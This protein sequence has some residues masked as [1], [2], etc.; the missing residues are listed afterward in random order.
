MDLTKTDIKRTIQGHLSSAGVGRGWKKYYT[1]RDGKSGDRICA[2][3]DLDMAGKT[4]EPGQ[5]IDAEAVT[6]DQGG[7]VTQQDWYEF[8][9]GEDKIWARRDQI[10][11]EHLGEDTLI[12]ER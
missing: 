5:V 3:H 12:F 1:L 10:K 4:A 2:L 7:T 8:W 11:E 6:K 9:V